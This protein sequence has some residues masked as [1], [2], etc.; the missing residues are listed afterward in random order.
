MG[1]LLLLLIVS[2]HAQ[3]FYIFISTSFNVIEDL[4][5]SFMYPQ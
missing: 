2:F 4:S 3:E 1:C 5:Y